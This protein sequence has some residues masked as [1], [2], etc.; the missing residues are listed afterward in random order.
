M[1]VREGDKIGEASI[2]RGGGVRMSMSEAEKAAKAAFAVKSRESVLAANYLAEVFGRE[3]EKMQKWR[4]N[5]KQCVLGLHDPVRVVGL[6]DAGAGADPEG[7]ASWF[8]RRWAELMERDKLGFR[9]YVGGEE[10]LDLK[11]T[12][13]DFCVSTREQDSHS[14]IFYVES[15]LSPLAGIFFKNVSEKPALEQ[16]LDV[17]HNPDAEYRAFWRRAH[18]VEEEMMKD[19]GI[20]VWLDNLRDLAL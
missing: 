6:H 14:V 18:A 2:K 10:V 20:D 17:L 12:D 15:R 16:A 3:S 13:A 4:G 19:G 9:K 7:S 11:S 8:R 1:S 5:V